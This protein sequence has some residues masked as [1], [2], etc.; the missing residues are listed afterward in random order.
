MCSEIGP[1]ENLRRGGY[2][3]ESMDG[4]RRKTYE[5]GGAGPAEGFD[6]TNGRP[7]CV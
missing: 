4:L 1:A 7:G 5:A 2:Q 6:G 3:T